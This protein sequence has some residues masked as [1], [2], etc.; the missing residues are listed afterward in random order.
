[1]KLSLLF[2]L[3][4]LSGFAQVTSSSL[5]KADIF[6]ITQKFKANKNLVNEEMRSRFPIN[7]IQGSEYVSFLAKVGNDFDASEMRSRGIDIGARI[8]NIV[9]IRYPLN[10]LNEI[11][12]ENTLTYIKIAAKI[13]PMLDKVVIGTHVDSVWAGI[14]LP[15]GYTG[16]DIIIGITDWGFD[17]THPMFYDTLLQNSRIIAAWDQFKT[18]GPSPA[19]YGYGAEYSTFS[20]LES[21]GSDTSNF[22]GFATHGSHVAGIAGGSGA[23]LEYRGMAF[24]S[25]YLFVTF[26]FDESFVLDAWEWMYDKATNEGKRLV[27]SMSWGIYHMGALDGTDILSQAIDSYS[28]Q[29]VLFV[30]SAGNNGNV[31]FHIEKDFAS[32]DT[33]KS[34]IEFDT[35][36]GTNGH[37][38]QSIH[39]WG[40]SGNEI[41]CQ[42]LATDFSNN[43][44]GSSQW[45]ASTSAPAYLDTFAIIGTDTIFFNLTTD[46]SYPSNG[47]PHMR[48]RVKYD[49]LPYWIGI[50]ATAPSGV[51]HMWNLTELSTNVG[52]WGRSFLSWGSGSTSG[53]NM[54]GVGVPACANKA[55][56][57]GAYSSEYYSISGNLISGAGASFSSNGP[58]MDGS[59]KPDISAPGVNV[60]S[61]I[62]SF[63]NSSF[64]QIDAV[65]FN[66]RTYPFARFSGTSMSAPVCAGVA[67]LMLDANPFLSAD[68]LKNIIITT[69]R[70]DNYTGVIP[71]HN[72]KWGWG[73]LNAYQAVKLAITVVGLH[74]FEKNKNW[75]LV[76][77][78]ATTAITV[79]GVE[80][81]IDDIKII[82]AA[83]N[84]VLQ[85]KSSKNIYIGN[86]KSGTYF[87]RLVVGNK[88]EQAR[89]I[90]TN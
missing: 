36:T 77:N 59:L 20:E 22:Y 71:P 31:N 46:A 30:S 25:E 55:V 79:E 40:E 52:N 56:A 8:N 54:Y 34:R 80:G 50:R 89:F 10:T 74:N 82:D 49:N 58:L 5:T 86:I 3:F 9:S 12:Q 23:G 67:A 6:E 44:V 14:G 60:A 18:S 39:L 42:L 47:R 24:E 72:T 57:V 51:V 53:D 85:P 28:S 87:L 27:V 37:W 84:I 17:Y 13:K 7:R 83:G 64:S 65:N 90:K 15:Q 75:T 73:K 4:T 68:Q 43:S 63:T 38:G 29:G 78:P 16:K 69:A 26:Q 81:S 2:I 19:P 66:G 35:N 62:S 48:L 21:A 41:S 76:P 33:L 45:F 1:M 11:F 88:V 70:T 32:A 61:S